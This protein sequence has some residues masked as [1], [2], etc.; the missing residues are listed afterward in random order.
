MRHHSSRRPTRTNR[1]PWPGVFIQP[2][3]SLEEERKRKEE[4]L[5]RLKNLKREEIRA[6]LEKIRHISGGGLVRRH[7]VRGQ[8]KHAPRPVSRMCVASNPTL[9][10][11]CVCLCQVDEAALEGDF[12]PETWDQQMA[13]AFGEEYYDHVRI[14]CCCC[15][16]RC[17][18][19]HGLFPGLGGHESN[20]VCR[21]AGG[22]GASP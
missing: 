8:G 13:Q 11:C 16:C 19:C 21:T 2:P 4:E 5:R 3:I 20:G 17:R 22:G 7:L 10:R 18:L 1:R 6:R 12:D 14:W 9:C 15:C